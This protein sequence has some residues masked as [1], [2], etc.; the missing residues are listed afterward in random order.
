MPKNWYYAAGQVWPLLVNSSQHRETIPYKQVA[1]A[2]GTNP[3]SVGNAL[4]PIQDY[5]LENHLPPLTSIVVRTSTGIPGNGFIAW[6]VDD[7]HSA[8]EAVFDFNWNL[9][10][11]PYGSFGIDD[12]P[13]S[14]AKA[15]IA[16]PDAS[17]DL[18]T[19]VRVRGVAQDI[20]RAALRNA[21]NN[22]CAICQFSFPDAL[23]AAHIIP[24]GRA[25]AEQR[26]D[27]RNGVLL[28]SLHHRL[29]D[30]GLITISTSWEVV[31]YDP[32]MKDGP[33]SDVDKQMT[34]NLHG[35]K[36]HL[37]ANALLRPSIQFLTDHHTQHEY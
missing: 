12:T 10:Q 34:V 1:Q 33:Y 16:N 37:P 32:E 27:P 22:K 31:Y 30:A 19:K 35:K 14:L 13:E 8:H 29:F 25:S 3:L 5:C 17:T 6:D 21:Y 36:A 28:C 24:W 18:Y 11:N 4:G 2:I 9:V 20:F 7:L 15:I 23:D 26:L